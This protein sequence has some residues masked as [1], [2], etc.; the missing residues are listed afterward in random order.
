[1]PIV[2]DENGE[3]MPLRTGTRSLAT[4]RELSID[5]IRTMLYVPSILEGRRPFVDRRDWR[6]ILPLSRKVTSTARHIADPHRRL[7]E[8]PTRTTTA[9]RI[10]VGCLHWDW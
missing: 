8:V 6:T 3:E 5:W 1:M 10:L 2:G 4:T 7:P 9:A